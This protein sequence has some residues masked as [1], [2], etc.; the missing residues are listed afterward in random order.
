MKKI[1]IGLLCVM[2]FI[3]STFSVYADAMDHSEN[4]EYKQQ[5][6]D[7]LIENEHREPGEGDWFAGGWGDSAAF[8]REAT[9]K[10]PGGRYPS[11]YF[12]DVDN[13]GEKEF[14][15]NDDGFEASIDNALWVYDI[16]DGKLTASYAGQGQD[17]EI[18]VGDKDYVVLTTHKDPFFDQFIELSENV[19]IDYEAM[20]EKTEDHYSMKPYAKTQTSND[21]NKDN[22]YYYG[23][24]LVNEGEYNYYSQKEITEDEYKKIK[25]DLIK[26]K[27]KATIRY[28]LIQAK[29]YYN[30]T[31]KDKRELLSKAYDSSEIVIS[32]EKNGLPGDVDGDGVITSGDAL[33]ILRAS[34]DLM[35]L[36]DDVKK[37]A[38]IN[39]DTVIDSGDAISVL[40]QSLGL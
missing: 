28:D 4:E 39:S 3:S 31:E 20:L 17:L 12:L 23:Y 16:A 29:D 15:V 27:S 5:L 18:Y 8:Y 2:V 35:E 13:D 38:D 24:E 32:N 10:D 9:E 11:M 40:R 19:S 6:I 14:I 26:D 34:A 22:E 33:I 7:L 37:L 21:N 25:N 1:I 36:E 30:L